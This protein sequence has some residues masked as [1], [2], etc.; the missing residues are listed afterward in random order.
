MSQSLPAGL[1]GGRAR[2]Q[3]PERRRPAPG[4]LAPS[5]QTTEVIRRAAEN[6]AVGASRGDR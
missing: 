5:L 2:G 3:A 6:A 4:A 1:S